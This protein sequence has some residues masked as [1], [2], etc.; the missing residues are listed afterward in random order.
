M[1]L[2]PER[3]VWDKSKKHWVDPPGDTEEYPERACPFCGL[4]CDADWCDIGV[5]MIQ[6]GPYHCQWCMASEVGTYD[7]TDGR[8]M[9]Y[10]W[11]LPA[12]PAGST[13]NTVA[14]KIVGHKEAMVAYR[15][16]LLDEDK[17]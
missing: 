6:S 5:G 8:E 13:V 15:A 17:S 3:G 16:G 9:E 12:S 7:K 4:M 14:G 2:K 11:Y 10:G 1:T